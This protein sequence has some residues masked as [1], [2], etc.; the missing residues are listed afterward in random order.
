M[1][2]SQ[3]GNDRPI[4]CSDRHLDHGPGAD[5]CAV[6]EERRSR[7]G[8]A[9]RPGRGTSDEVRSRSGDH[10]P[11]RPG[12]RCTA[13]RRDHRP[14]AP[15]PVRRRTAPSPGRRACGRRGPRGRRWPDRPA[16][17]PSEAVA[18]P[19]PCGQGPRPWPT[20]RGRRTARHDPWRSRGRERRG[21]V[22]T[23]TARTCAAGGSRRADPVPPRR[24]CAGRGCRSVDRCPDGWGRALAGRRGPRRTGRGCAAYRAPWPPP[25]RACG[26]RGQSSPRAGPGG[27]PGGHR[28]APPGRSGW[29]C[30]R[31]GAGGRG[32][33]GGGAHRRRGR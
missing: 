18:V 13:D 19:R 3:S 31:P 33:G 30:S 21:P 1:G 2:S 5:R 12:A 25:R 17:G 22:R 32:T 23:S 10:P 16:A 15:R 6:V 26:A 11:V 24:S 20:G 4:G 29:A 28:A 27:V 9:E 7:P 14:S 8:P